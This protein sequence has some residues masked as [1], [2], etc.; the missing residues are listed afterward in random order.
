MQFA[1]YDIHAVNCAVQ[2]ILWG[3]NV[4]FSEKI[5]KCKMLYMKYIV[6]YTAQ[7][8]VQYLVSYLSMYVSALLPETINNYTDQRHLSPEEGFR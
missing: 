6:P 1:L 7:Y 4:Q 8:T 3:R 5:N 2:C